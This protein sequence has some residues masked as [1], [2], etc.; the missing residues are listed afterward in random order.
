MYSLPPSLVLAPHSPN[1]SESAVKQ[2]TIGRKRYSPRK[3]SPFK[4]GRNGKITEK[5]KRESQEPKAA[6][7]RADLENAPDACSER[8]KDLS[9]R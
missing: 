5:E 9:L 4:A 7:K 6:N 8:L 1:A 2:K 3:E